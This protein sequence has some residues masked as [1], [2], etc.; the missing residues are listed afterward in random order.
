MLKSLYSV[1]ICKNLHICRMVNYFD[2]Y[3]SNWIVYTKP[4]I[5]DFEFERHLK[6]IKT[7]SCEIFDESI[8]EGRR[9]RRSSL[10]PCL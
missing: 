9:V 10:V 5:S 4:L 3:L 2:N 6:S 1:K 7:I 8:G